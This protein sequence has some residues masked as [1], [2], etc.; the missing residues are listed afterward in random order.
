MIEGNGLPSGW[1]QSTLGE[2]R[3]DRSK[4]IEPAKFRE[5]WFELYSVSSFDTGIPEIVQGQGSDSF[6]C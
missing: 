5:K 2:L 4:G 6:K 1:A 3:V